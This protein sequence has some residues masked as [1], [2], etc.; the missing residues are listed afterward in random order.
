MRESKSIADAA[1]SVECCR[2]NIL[3]NPHTGLWI[4]KNCGS[5]ME[6]VCSSCS[7]SRF[8]SLIDRVEAGLVGITPDQC[9]HV[10][11]TFKPSK[12]WKRRA[13]QNSVTP[14]LLTNFDKRLKRSFDSRFKYA[15][16][17]ELTDTRCHVHMIFVLNTPMTSKDRSTIAAHS[18]HVSA[19]L[20]RNKQGR[21]YS[22]GF[23]SV[24]P[25]ESQEH[26]ENLVKYPFKDS[27]MSLTELSNNKELAD[28]MDRF[29]VSL[30]NEGK[31]RLAPVRNRSL[32]GGCG[33]RGSRTRFSSNWGNT[34]VPDSELA[35]SYYDF[36]FEEDLPP[37]SRI[38]ELSPRND[39]VLEKIAYSA[40]TQET[41]PSEPPPR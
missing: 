6:S 16:G 41:P 13:E 1:A 5:R 31:H 33:F 36:G 28:R 32:Q 11:L 27:T 23:T 20:R 7:E 25:V 40:R 18:R 35:I 8:N 30:R 3:R 14:D 19:H 26:M 10:T 2:P 21:K 17:I 22:F 39:F 4:A 9:A 37:L 15:T 38:R 29:I 12:S 34:L 24:K